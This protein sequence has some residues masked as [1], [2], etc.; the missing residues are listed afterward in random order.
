[1]NQQGDALAAAGNMFL[2]LSLSFSHPCF[3]F[4]FFFFFVRRIPVRVTAP[5][6]VPTSETFRGYQLN[7]RGYRYNTTQVYTSINSMNQQGDARAAAGNRTSPS[8]GRG[9]RRVLLPQ[10]EGA[11]SVFT[12]YGTL[13]FFESTKSK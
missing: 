8:P 9:V 7:H 13:L 11:P 2:S 3:F 1:M 6:F 10:R 5:R 12:K 4:F